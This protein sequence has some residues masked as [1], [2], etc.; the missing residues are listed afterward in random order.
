M[1][2]TATVGGSTSN[3]YVTR[4]EA[5]AYFQLG[6]HPKSLTWF[7]LADEAKD[8]YLILATTQIDALP[9]NGAKY[10]TA[11]TSGVPDQSLKFPRAQDYDDSTEY[12]PDP[13]KR[14]TY[15]QAIWLAL[16]SGDSKREQLQAQGVKSVSIADV[17]E[18]YGDVSYRSPFSQ[19]GPMAKNIILGARLVR[20]GGKWG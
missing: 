7:D 2:L 20:R 9:I 15:E 5:N 17:S 18:T 1:A 16:G 3:S 19:L 10:D 13:V 8:E 14:A 12:I 11:M 4:A 6:T